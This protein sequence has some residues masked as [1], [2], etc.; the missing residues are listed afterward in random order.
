MKIL[1]IDR[2][3]EDATPE[4]I[5]EQFL[6]EINRCVQ[7]YLADIIR[8]MYFRQDRSGTVLVLEA[9]SLEEAQSLLAKMPLVAAGQVQYD[10]I[11]LGPYMP[12]GLLLNDESMNAPDTSL[13]EDE[14]GSAM[15]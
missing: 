4:R 9:P 1:A 11:P 8:E 7:F 5:K 10:C 2:V 3:S 15:Q 14:S 12:L 6:K 13:L